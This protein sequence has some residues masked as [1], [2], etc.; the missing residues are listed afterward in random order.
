VKRLRPSLFASTDLVF[1]R[2]ERQTL[3][4]CRALGITTTE[5]VPAQIN[6]KLRVCRRGAATFPETVPNV[7]GVTRNALWSARP[8]DVAVSCTL[9]FEFCVCRCSSSRFFFDREYLIRLQDLTAQLLVGMPTR[10]LLAAHLSSFPLRL[11]R[12]V[13]GRNDPGLPRPYSL[14]GDTNDETANPRRTLY[15]RSVRCCDG[16]LERGQQRNRRTRP[17]RLAVIFH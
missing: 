4:N 9:Q 1:V 11:A 2:D 7:A 3:R 14:Q 13:R 8:F 10:Y 16:F 12:A 17:G 6:W 15:V 5:A